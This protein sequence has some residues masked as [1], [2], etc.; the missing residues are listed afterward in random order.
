MTRIIG[1]LYGPEGPL[2]GRL[3]LKPSAPFI[4]AP[5]DGISFKIENGIVDIE[6]PANAVNTVWLA[7]WK[8]KFDLSP[9]AYIEQW[10]VPPQAVA[11]IEEVRF[12]A[13]GMVRNRAGAKTDALD[14]TIWKQQAQEAEASAKA[15]ELEN[16]RLVSKLGQAES[17][18]AAANG[19]VAALNAQIGIL[20]RKLAEASDLQVVKEERIVE[21]RLLPEEAKQVIT[22]ERE[23]RVRL[24]QKIDA[25]QMEMEE[26]NAL[27]FHFASLKDEI[28]RLTRD[29]Y[30]LRAQV[31]ELKQPVR[32]STSLR[33]EAIANLDR[34]V[35]S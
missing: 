18:A 14:A 29:N 11:T 25:M 17:L 28:D 7:D 23:Q 24:Q 30:R 8:D 33:R 6:L 15:L 10:R 2:N 20:Q 31:E 35:G 13:S 22:E 16:V 4:G 21:R 3:F 32:T 1:E 27:A 34:L 19:K 12:G 9:V 5:K 26:K